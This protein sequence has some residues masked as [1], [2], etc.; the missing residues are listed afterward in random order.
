MSLGVA[1]LLEFNL[2]KLG[3]PDASW[4]ES[5]APQRW[6]VWVLSSAPSV[7]GV[8]SVD[9]SIGVSWR[10]RLSPVLWAQGNIIKKKI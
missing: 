3:P 10:L 1:A 8:C 5:L 9:S 6:S 4:D 7:D 2:G